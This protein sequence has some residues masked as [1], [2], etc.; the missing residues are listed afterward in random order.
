[1]GRSLTLDVA[2]WAA[3]LSGKTGEEFGAA[4]ATDDIPA[5]RRRRLPPFTRNVLRCALPLLRTAPASPVVFAAE[6]GDLESTVALL[7]DLARG[8]VLSPA[9]FALSVHNA[10]AGAL[11]L[12]VSPA[13][14]HTAI[15][16]GPYSFAAGLT[17]AFLR[18]NDGAADSVILVL[19]EERL[20]AVYAA[21]DS[22]APGAFLAMRLRLTEDADKS[23]IDTAPGRAGVVAAVRALA[24]GGRRVRFTPPMAEARAA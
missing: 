18:L 24:G 5:Q 22:D 14:D 20:P 11:S 16:G 15:A 3:V 17:E 8:E 19:A 1:M 23:A 13:G 12:C 21:F 10:P 2:E 7:G 9:L 6:H 4:I